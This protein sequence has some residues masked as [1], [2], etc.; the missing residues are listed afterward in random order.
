MENIA[1]GRFFILIHK[2]TNKGT[3][4]VDYSKE[5]KNQM[6]KKIRFCNLRTASGQ[7]ELKNQDYLNV[8]IPKSMGFS[9]SN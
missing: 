3:Q 9:Q 7:M 2:V 4:Y 5:R 8:S 6:R 1:D